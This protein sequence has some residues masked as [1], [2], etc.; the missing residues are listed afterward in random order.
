MAAWHSF[1]SACVLPILE[2][3]YP[4]RPIM[5]N[6]IAHIIGSAAMHN[7]SVR[8]MVGKALHTIWEIAFSIWCHM[9]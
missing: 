9:G 6:I 1:T 8:D 2:F 5:Q 7:N 3:R 4:K